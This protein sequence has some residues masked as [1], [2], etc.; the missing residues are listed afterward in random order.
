MYREACLYDLLQTKKIKNKKPFPTFQRPPRVSAYNP[1]DTIPA[2]TAVF[3]TNELLSLILSNASH[4]D[5]GTSRCA[6]KLWDTVARDIKVHV[7]GPI[8]VYIDT[9]HAYP[10]YCENQQPMIFNPAVTFS[11]EFWKLG[12]DNNVCHMEFSVDF[13]FI[14]FDLRRLGCEFLTNPPIT[15]VALTCS[16]IGVKH[17]GESTEVSLLCVKDGI[18]L[19]HLAEVFRKLRRSSSVLPCLKECKGHRVSAHLIGT[20]LSLVDDLA[21]QLPVLEW[22]KSVE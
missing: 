21:E 14:S 8:R 17:G 19:W 1:N 10:E 5:L 6:C 4:E 11:E 13:D 15:Q 7:M 22:L 9:V 18:R 20:R 3:G 12:S 16:P 2:R